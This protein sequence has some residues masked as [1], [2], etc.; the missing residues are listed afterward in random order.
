MD[1]KGRKVNNAPIIS[2]FVNIFILPLSAEQEP[3]LIFFCSVWGGISKNCSASTLDGNI[4]D[5]ETLCRSS[6]VLNIT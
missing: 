1:L 3:L 4:F 2:C 6:V 5:V